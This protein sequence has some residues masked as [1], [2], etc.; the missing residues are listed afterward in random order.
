MIYLDY[1]ANTPAD[2]RVLERF[3]EVERSCPGNANSR[4]QAGRDAKRVI[5]HATQSIAGL[6]SAQPAEVIYTSGAS[7]AN[8]FALKGLAKLSRHLGRHIISTPLEHSSVSGTLTALQEHGYEI[9]LVDIRRDGTIDLEHLKELLRPDTIAVAVTLVDSELGVVQ[10][11]KEISEILQAWP[12]CHLHV[13]ATQA[14][15]KIPVSFEGV[16]TM[17]LTAHKFY[18]LNGIGLL[19]K[20]RRLALE[21]LIHG[22]ESTTIYRSG[23]P[24]VALAASLETALNS[25]VNELPERSARVKEANLYLRTAL[26]KYPKVRINS[27]ESA[28]PH[29]LNLSV[30]NV[31]GTVFQRELDA[32]GVCISVKSA[33]SSDGLPSR[34]VFAVSRDR[35]NA[36]SSWRISLS[37]LTTQEELD[38]FLRAFDA[39]YTRL[40]Q[41][42]EKRKDRAM[43]REMEPYQLI[44]RSIIKKYRKELWTPFIVAVKRYELIKAGDKI[45]VCISGGK[46]SMLMAKLMQELQRHSDVPFELVFLVMDPGYNEINRQKIESNAELLHIPVTIFESNIFSVANN[47]DKNP[48]YLCAR[49][50][51]GHLY[52]K[53][54]ELGCNKIALGHHFNDVIETTVM[55]MFYGSQLQAMP[56]M[57]HSTSFPGMTLIRPMYCIREEDILA[58]KRYNEL[59]FIQCACRF[60]ENCTMCDNGGGGSKR[61]ETKILLRRLKRDNPN[62]E[63]SIFRSIHAVALDTMPGYK[64][65]GVEHSFLERFHAQ[66]E[67]FN[68]E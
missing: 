47:T 48:C 36:L 46:D 26:S 62:I 19:L 30:E 28:I 66:E 64:S 51:R 59:E 23:T 8:N 18:G 13:D 7:E 56:P 43:K 60:T 53:A 55:S 41:L 57:L 35:K 33:C 32:E 61:Q 20:R 54:K 52:S 4:H 27:P 16:D 29:I 11:V 14:V 24:T 2:S 15:G 45:A 68:E 21:P 6:L 9:D 63:N 49:M 67:A 42:G 3:C 38:G 58:W 40:T 31:K 10:P 12:N 50:R 5:D 37:H 22:G 65:E 44:E 25:A 1:S 34:A 17:S 39:C